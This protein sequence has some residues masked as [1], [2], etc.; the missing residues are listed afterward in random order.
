MM[1]LHRIIGSTGHVST[2][3]ENRSSDLD[4]TI[5]YLTYFIWPSA[6]LTSACHLHQCEVFS[7]RE[8]RC[9]EFHPLRK[10]YSPSWRHRHV[11]SSEST[12]N[13]ENPACLLLLLEWNSL[14][15]YTRNWSQAEAPYQLIRSRLT[16]IVNTFSSTDPEL[17]IS[18]IRHVRTLG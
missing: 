5:C 14:R 6:V 11:C 13:H 3:I 18:V 2:A 17:G 12:N 9:D 15:S 4:S 7:S 10:K 8:Y 16:I 1:Q